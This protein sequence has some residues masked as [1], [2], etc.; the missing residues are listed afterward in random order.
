M[1]RPE[2]DQPIAHGPYE[3][4]RRAW[5]TSTFDLAT[6]ATKHQLH[7]PYQ[8]MDVLLAGCNVELA[9]S[10]A[11]SLDDAIARLSAFRAG[12]YVS[13]VSPFVCPFVT[14]ESVNAYS[15]INER[16]SALARGETPKIAS[17]FSSN[18]GKLEA[19]PLELSLACVLL[20]DQVGVTAAQVEA[21]GQFAAT[22]T[23]VQAQY[24]VLR[25]FSGALQAA[26]QLLALDQSLLHIWTGI[27][28]LFPTVDSEVSFRL[29]LYVSVLCATPSD[30]G[31][32][33]QFVRT[34]YRLRSKVAHGT[35]SKVTPEQWLSA[36][37][38]LVRC[39]KAVCQRQALPTESELLEELFAGVGGP[40]ILPRSEQRSA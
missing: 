28:S 15:G 27:E 33:H 23:R 21:A 3:M 26:P 22:W 16:D 13:G 11:A 19:W 12:L 18:S 4:C 1:L 35:S 20:R 38:L 30:R 6:L 40:G 39:A 34:G 25:A 7:L 31:K 2:F 24:P 32:L 5:G 9:I 37:S 8:L 17:S 10:D 36:W 14:S 29:A